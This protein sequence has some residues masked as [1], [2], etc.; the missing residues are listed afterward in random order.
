MFLA[1][2]LV[3]AWSWVIHVPFLGGLL[4]ASPAL[5][6]IAANWDK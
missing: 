6:V 2:S 5:A 3:E 4:L 1:W